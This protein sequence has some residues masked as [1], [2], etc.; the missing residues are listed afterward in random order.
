MLGV[1]KLKVLV[2]AIKGYFYKLLI[3]VHFL[4]IPSLN[5]SC[6]IVVSLTSY[7]RRVSDCV[8]YYTIVSLLR[9]K[10]QPQRIILWLAKDEWND[11]R[12]PR[13]IINLREKGVEIRYCKDLRSFKKL[14]PTLSLCPNNNIMTVDDDIIYTSDTIGLIWK[15]HLQN[16]S[17]IIGFSTL[18]PIIENGT[19]SHYSDWKHIPTNSKGLLIFPV[20]CGGILYPAGSLNEIVVREDLFVKLC[21]IAD[22]IW[23][24]FCGL[25][26]NS[27]K[28]ALKK[29][30][31]DMSF[32]ALYQYFHKGSALTHS[33]RFEHANDKQFKELFEHYNAFMDSTGKLIR[34]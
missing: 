33:N 4:S 23:F 13:K 22:D 2:S 21:P 27:N 29:K 34:K 10:C 15:E 20:G 28:I 6:N 30:S 24:W 1:E 31:S 17:E 16:H 12:L 8:V 11:E 19:P 32:D 14:I 26:N 18:T 25:L 3:D 9:Q 7:G 5:S